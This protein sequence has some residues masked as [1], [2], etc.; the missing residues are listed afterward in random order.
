MFNILR[1]KKQADNAKITNA[2]EHNLRLRTQSNIDLSRTHLN[3]ILVN[4]LNA[5][6]TNASDFQKKLNDF[7]EKELEIKP[8]ENNVKLMEW[9][10]SASPE[11]FKK[12]PEKEKE[13]VKSQVDFFK[14]E[15]GDNV[16]LAV[17]HNDESTKHIHFMVSTEEKKVMKYKNQKGE[18][19]KEKWGLNARRFNPEFLK[20]LHT[21]HAEHN[22]NFGLSRGVKNSNSKHLSV[23]DFYK[24]IDTV[25]STNYEKEIDNLFKTKNEEKIR[26]TMLILV[27]KISKLKKYLELTHNQKRRK[28]LA[29]KEKELEEMEKEVLKRENNVKL[30]ERTVKLSIVLENENIQLKKENR[31]LKIKV[32]HF[33]FM[34]N[35]EKE[36]HKFATEKLKSLKIIQNGTSH[37]PPF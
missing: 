14:K 11:F 26:K 37:K 22:K 6:L 19:F 8:K 34:E 9:V 28:E 13:W 17:L 29:N 4:S 27:E 12:Y 32:G 10:V 30:S 1:T 3:E 15:F 5:S 7:Y 2:I 33:E 31:E 16:K 24:M 20:E 36:R 21:R 35:Q 25:Q 23:K 18:F